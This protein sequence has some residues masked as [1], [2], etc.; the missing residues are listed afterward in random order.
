M[1]HLRNQNSY[2]YEGNRTTHAWKLYPLCICFQ[3]LREVKFVVCSFFLL[4]HALREKNYNI[5]EK[6]RAAI[7]SH[8]H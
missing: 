2:I 8:K 4:H 6:P 7:F 3:V 5:L 1:F